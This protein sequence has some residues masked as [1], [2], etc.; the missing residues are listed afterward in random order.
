M[1]N[2]C[3]RGL[4]KVILSLQLKGHEMFF[5]SCSF[6][7]TC[8][9]LCSQQDLRHEVNWM[10]ELIWLTT[11]LKGNDRKIQ[12]KHYVSGMKRRGLLI[13]KLHPGIWK[14]TFKPSDLQLFNIIHHQKI[15]LAENKFTPEF[16]CLSSPENC[17]F[18]FPNS[19]ANMFL[20]RVKSAWNS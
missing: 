18:K 10:R 2:S 9:S 13:V 16:S 17:I 20:R 3:I 6:I 8:P 5:P 1:S 19:N 12:Y 14:I 11:N 4:K 15:L 7:C